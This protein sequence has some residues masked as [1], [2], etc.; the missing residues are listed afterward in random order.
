MRK[1]PGLHTR[2]PML[3]VK[4]GSAPQANTCD[5]HMRVQATAAAP[6][7]KRRRIWEIS[8]NVHCSIIG[9]CL[10]TAELRQILVKMQLAGAHK[11]SDH[12]LHGQ[13]VLLAGRRDHA[14]KL[15]QKALDRRH[16]SAIGQFAKARNVED[17]RNLWTRAVQRAEIPGAYWAI[18]THPLTTEDLVRH[19]FGEVHMLS[20][21]VGAANRADIR[22]LRELE[23]ETA[24]LKDK[25]ARQQRQLRDAFVLRD[26]TIATLTEALSKAIASHSVGSAANGGAGEAESETTAEL[27]SELRKRLASRTASCEEMQRRLQRLKVELDVER[28]RRFG[29][30]QRESELR[31]ELEAA[32]RSLARQFPD[33]Q[34]SSDRSI[35]L[36]GVTI[37]YVGGRTTNVVQLRMLSEEYG[38]MFLHHD[39]GV[40]DRSGLLASHVAQADLVYFPV[41]CVSHTAV[42]VTKRMAQKLGKPYVALRSSGLTS[43]VSALRRDASAITGNSRT[44]LQSPR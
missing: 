11:D 20:H 35:D 16:R 24:A 39:G 31:D 25:V 30:E 7:P 38:A 3:P 14:S 17:L 32:E 36:S 41:D 15:L 23:I 18:L 42:V 19:V 5:A 22:R 1:V 43:F 26:A 4:V 21:L 9:T 33:G 34:P 37:L 44:C 6:A 12:E 8:S 13:S 2:L 40:D 27:V 28:K 10:T 29:L